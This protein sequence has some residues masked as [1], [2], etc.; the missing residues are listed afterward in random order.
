MVGFYLSKIPLFK[1]RDGRVMDENETLLLRL[2]IPRMAS[3]PTSS[4]PPVMEVAGGVLSSL[5]SMSVASVPAVIVLPVIEVVGSVSSSLPSLSAASF[6]TAIVHSVVEVAGGVSSSTLPLSAASVST[7]I[8]HLVTKVV[9]GVF[10][11]HLSLSAV[12]VLAAIVPLTVGAIGD[13]PSVLSLETSTSCQLT[14][15]IKIKKNRIKWRQKEPWK[16]KML[17][18][19][20]EESR[21]VEW[22]LF[23]KLPTLPNAVQDFLLDSSD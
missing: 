9:V 4:V 22:L 20:L 1:I 6:S 7:T 19:I 16:V 2:L 18:W 3:I 5:P 11:S 12:F 21:R 23:K 10:S 8:V 17:L 15:H 13:D 14:S